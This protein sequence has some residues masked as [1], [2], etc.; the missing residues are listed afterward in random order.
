[1]AGRTCLSPIL[2]VMAN[3][4]TLR[5]A[6]DAN[7]RGDTVEF[8]A[9][10]SSGPAGVLPP[11][12]RGSVDINFIAG[13]D[14]GSADVQFKLLRQST[15]ADNAPLD[16]A[17]AKN[18]LRPDS[19]PTD[20][21]DA[22]YANFTAD[23]GTT[24]GEF[25]ALL[26][27]AAT[28]LSQF[29]EYTADE[30]RL[31]AL[32][33]QQAGNSGAI[34]RRNSLGVFGRGFPDPTA[35]AATQDAAGNV[36]IVV[37]VQSRSFL[38]QPNSSYRGGNGDL[39]VLAIEN[40][41]YRLKESDGSLIVFRTD[42]R[43]DYRQDR[44]GDRVTA[45]YTDSQL[46]SY[47]DNFGNTTTLRYNAQGRIDRMTDAVGRVTNFTY[48]A[49]GEHL[50]S[51]VDAQGVRQFT[52]VTGQ[53]PQL[54]HALQSVTHLDGTNTSFT[55]DSRG[56]VSKAT[57][58]G[59]ANVVMYTYDGL[60]GVTVTNALGNSITTLVNEFGLP[61]LVR[62]GLDQ[63]TRFFYDHNRNLTETQRPDG[64]I[65]VNTPDSRGNPSTLVD[66]LGQSIS[67]TFDAV[68]NTL[69]MIRD[70]GGSTFSF[71]MDARG[72]P[73]S[74]T[75][76]DGSIEKFGFDT[77]GNLTSTIDPIGN[78]IRYVYDE[79]NLLIRQDFADGTRADFT[80]D[81]HFNLTSATNAVGKT[82][83]DYDLATDRLGKVTYPG[84]RSLSFTYDATGRRTKS[85]DQDGF[86]VNYSYDTLG[87]LSGLTD[88][89]NLSIVAYS[90]DDVGRLQRQ[91]QGNGTF[92]T[93]A[94]DVAGRLTSLVNLASDN[95]ILSTFGY[96][97]DAIGRKLTM[98]TT[99]GT[100]T[101]VYDASGQLT[102]VNLPDGGTLTYQ[103]DAAGN[104]VA[105]HD[106]GTTTT[107]STNSMN[108]YSGAG[109]MQFT[110]DTNGNLLSRTDSSGTTTYEYNLQG[111]LASVT[112]PSDS[113][114]YIYD[115]LGTRIATVQNNQRTDYLVDSAEYGNVVG[116]YDGS[117]SL[118]AH[119]VH[120]GGLISQVNSGG[121][122][123]YYHFDASGNT[124]QLTSGTGTVLSAYT[125]LPFGEIRSTAGTVV[126]PFTFHGQLGV[127]S[128]GQ[129]GYFMRARYYDSTI[130]RFTQPDPIGLAGGLNL[131]RFAD[132]N[133]ISFADPQGLNPDTII[134]S[135][136]NKLIAHVPNA[137]RADHFDAAV[138]RAFQETQTG[139]LKFDDAKLI[140]KL[141][142]L[143]R[144]RGLVSGP[145]AVLE[146]ATV[147]AA[148]GQTIV[149]A[150][151]AS[152]AIAEGS[153][154]EAT[155]ISA[156]QGV[157]PSV[158]TGF[159]AGESILGAIFAEGGVARPH[160]CRADCGHSKTF[161]I[162][163]SLR[164]PLLAIR[165]SPDATTSGSAAQTVPV[166]PR[167]TSCCSK[168]TPSKQVR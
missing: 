144:A 50:L 24:V 156:S 154:L 2:T 54:E 115:A 90:Y 152:V 49:S 6:G 164:K 143:V 79:H 81:A 56:R 128:E 153:V 37:G 13:T 159:V 26:D 84:G 114:R 40:G 60:G 78:Q 72:N 125:Y 8:L 117:G 104:R 35:L 132:N 67:A 161:P 88:G 33:L 30:G 107:Y 167:C 157:G 94:Y 64:T 87:R 93:Y 10:N 57:A 63:V 73:L 86:T 47:T 12:A 127:M 140:S 3:T 59:G 89:A 41:A 20:A 9:I 27:R 113:I 82:T 65:V 138:I 118:L 48:D 146:T 136:L 96:T 129:G 95:S 19:L 28:Y 141:R 42:G 147:D 11:G 135:L 17:A 166:S 102:S 91:D 160:W 14:V 23:V 83:Y 108:Q 109:S 76:P 137:L 51:I 151:G 4:S 139:P 16:W 66:P 121:D 116:M 39:G 38:I 158:S 134:L 29:G 18:Q 62:D 92:T 74:F 25:Q 120:A 149:T 165:F 43:L 168:G 145:A 124:A 105:V 46:T 148:L 119:Y 85:V 80:Y 103:Y 98:T 52:Y 53:G 22:I 7:A 45:G 122:A 112:T 111:Q 5:F 131:Y 32:E 55:Y 106:G 21:W 15:L 126:N 77:A 58:D 101:Y 71:R 1:M 97:Y 150:E 142:D 70:P 123:R 110:Y 162:N 75:Y 155:L 69:Q 36:T 100:T 99:E 133:P 68:F 34:T 31:L 44:N 61:T 130:G 163:S